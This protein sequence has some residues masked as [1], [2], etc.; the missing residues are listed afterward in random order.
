MKD[1]YG[2]YI[3]ILVLYSHMISIISNNDHFHKPVKTFDGFSITVCP[4]TQITTLFL[5]ALHS[6]ILLRIPG[7]PSRCTPRHLLYKRGGS[8]VGAITYATRN[9][10]RV[11]AGDIRQ[12]RI[13]YHCIT[14][15]SGTFG[16]NGMRR[17]DAVVL[18]ESYGLSERNVGRR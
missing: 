6:G 11:R 8:R 5:S 15:C 10:N 12:T 17:Y 18:V 2:H 9:R 1:T 7:W 3:M 16:G 4:G 14:P 13:Q